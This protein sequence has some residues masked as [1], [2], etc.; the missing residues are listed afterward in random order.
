MF[1]LAVQITF[2]AVNNLS[3]FCTFQ[4]QPM[5]LAKI[6]PEVVFNAE[7]TTNIKNIHQLNQ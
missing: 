3:T 4:L 5:N 7:R 1:S 6:I 2:W